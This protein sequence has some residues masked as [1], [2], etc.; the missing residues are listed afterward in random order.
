M[1]AAVATM[2]GSGV[3]SKGL[4]RP[5]PCPALAQKNLLYYRPPAPGYCGSR[6]GLR[7]RKLA[8][9]VQFC[10]L[11]PEPLFEKT[12]GRLAAA[13]GPTPP[14]PCICRGNSSRKKLERESRADR[15]CL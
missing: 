13:A 14:A 6:S 10:A 9:V 3:M 1:G 2:A 15:R 12:C 5:A 8:K 4:Y 11:H 7:G